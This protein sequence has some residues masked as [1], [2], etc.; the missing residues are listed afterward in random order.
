MCCGFQVYYLL[1]VL[2]PSASEFGLFQCVVVQAVC[3]AA[4]PCVLLGNVLHEHLRF[5][6]PNGNQK[7]H[8]EQA[9]ATMGLNHAALEMHHRD[10]QQPAQEPGTASTLK[11]QVGNFIM[12]MI[13][14][15][16]AYRF[17]DNKPQTLQ[18]YHIENS[19]QLMLFWF[20]LSRNWGKLGKTTH[21]FAGNHRTKLSP[22]IYYL[23]F[24]N[25]ASLLKI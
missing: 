5:W 4:E 15:L 2:H 21:Y 20:L 25:I 8:E 1:P 16:S 6:I 23:I 19:K 14:I 11:A 12:C 18:G 17:F 13:S 3:R 7:Q 22:I 10:H 9:R 24:F